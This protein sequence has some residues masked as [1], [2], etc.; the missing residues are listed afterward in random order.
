MWNLS[1]V[2]WPIVL[3]MLWALFVF[4]LQPCNLTLAPCRHRTISYFCAFVLLFLLCCVLKCPP[5][6]SDSASLCLFRLSIR[7]PPMKPFL[8]ILVHPLS[9]SVTPSAYF[10]HNLCL[11][12][13]LFVQMS[14]SSTSLSISGQVLYYTHFHDTVPSI[15]RIH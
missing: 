5:D 9:A 11:L 10:Y 14:V 8:I 15:I 1:F 7:T 3:I 4:Q 12:F 2:F 6:P 13:Q